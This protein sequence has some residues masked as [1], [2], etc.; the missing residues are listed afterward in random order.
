MSAFDVIGKFVTNKVVRVASFIGFAGS[1]F[2]F[3]WSPVGAFLT[4][5]VSAT[6][7]SMGDNFK[8]HNR[9]MQLMDGRHALRLRLMDLGDY[10]TATDDLNASLRELGIEPERP[11]LTEA[12]IDAINAEIDDLLS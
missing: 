11:K 5:L 9:I 2:L 3:S 1:G 8:H 12:E 4:L 10:K 6:V 7:Q